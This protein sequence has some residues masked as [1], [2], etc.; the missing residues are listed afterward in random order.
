MIDTATFVPERMAAAADAEVTA[1]TD[2]A[3][4]LVGAGTPFRDAHAIVGELVRRHL[5]DGTPLR[6]LVL[7]D[8]RLGADAAA[9]VAPGIGVQR[10]TSPGGAGPGPV[11]V[12]F[13]RF[14]DQLRHQREMLF[15]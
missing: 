6:E 15:M 5:A 7:A 1:A 2:L 9:L 4:W 11:A 13:T 3:E 14:A 10:R 12:Q 8:A